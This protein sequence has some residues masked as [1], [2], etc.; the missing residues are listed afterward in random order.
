[1]FERLL[2]N[3]VLT[4]RQAPLFRHYLNRHIEVDT[5]DH[6]PGAQQLLQRLIGADPVRQRQADDAA[7]AAVQ[8]RLHFWDDVRAALQEVQP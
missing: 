2:H 7:L 6:E 1:M 3:S 5:Q 4:A 8:S